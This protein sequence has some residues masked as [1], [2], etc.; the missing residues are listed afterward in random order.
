MLSRNG[1]KRR[2]LSTLFL[3]W[4]V[5][6]WEVLERSVFFEKN[7]H[8][9]TKTHNYLLKGFIFCKECGRTIGINTCGKK[10]YCVCNYYRK[11]GKKK[12]VCTAH[13]FVYED[14]EKL[15]LKNIKKECLQYV[16]IT[17]LISKLKENIQGKEIQTNLKL[18]IDKSKYE[19]TKLNKTLDKMYKRLDTGIIG[20]EQYI[21]LRKET[22]AA[23][24]Y[25]QNNIKCYE[26]DLQRIVNKY[27]EEPNYTKIVKEFLSL[28]NP[29]KILIAKLIKN[30]YISEEGIIDIHYKINKPYKDISTQNRAKL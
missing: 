27:V 8:I 13:R 3:V 20:E 6:D 18:K 7:S 2:K 5:M 29:N 17:N 4:I 22:E 14:L 23:I 26:K 25:Q 19:I 1:V 21:R 15:I 24:N 28:K 10:G 11:Y 12:E 30:I 9:T 16:N